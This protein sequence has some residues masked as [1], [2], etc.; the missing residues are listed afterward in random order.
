MLISFF[1]NFVDEDLLKEHLNISEINSKCFVFTRYLKLKRFKK[2]SVPFLFLNTKNIFL[3]YIFGVMYD[4][5]INDED[6]DHL[7][8]LFCDYDFVEIKVSKFNATYSEFIKDEFNPTRD[9]YLSFCFVA[10]TDF[11]HF[12]ALRKNRHLSINYNKKLLL[13]LYKGG[14]NNELG[15]NRK[16]C[17]R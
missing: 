9:K 13:E 7:K 14:L 10:N 11:K 15:N 12:K 16:Q 4:I 17:K 1:N 6:L 3:D 2:N 8:M 5:E